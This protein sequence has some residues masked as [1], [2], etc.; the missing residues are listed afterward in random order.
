MAKSTT[1][2]Q[3]S[4]PSGTY[5]YS[6]TGLDDLGATEYTLVT[7]IQ[8][9]SGSVTDFKKE[10]EDCLKQ[11]IE[12]CKYSPRSD[13]LMI[14]LVGFAETMREI[15]GFKLLSECN[16]N[17]YDNCLNIR[18]STALFL[19]S[20]NAIS[21]TLDYGRH[22]SD[23]DFTV[24]AVIFILTDGADNNS[25]RIGKQHVRDVLSKA[26]KEESL[27]SIQT[28]LIGIGTDD[29]PSL[30]PCLE[31]FKNDA[32]LSQYVPIKKADKKTLAKLGGFVSQSISEVSKSLGSGG[33]SQLL[34]F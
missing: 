13:N 7:I 10:M 11:I 22:L 18:G 3:R 20:E 14:R 15:H 2:E 25:G 19:T 32:G 12:S 24:N 5:G 33:A 21:A 1:L 8:D 23:N 34:Q 17:N 26:L 6:A 9:E 28:I 31:G 16:V 27:E 4:L 29:D 30:T